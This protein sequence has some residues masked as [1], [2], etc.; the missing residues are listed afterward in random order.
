MN[1][2]LSK[3]FDNLSYIGA[4]TNVER[5][6]PIETGSARDYSINSNDQFITKRNKRV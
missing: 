3:E 1:L 6:I 5:S 4:D 2:N